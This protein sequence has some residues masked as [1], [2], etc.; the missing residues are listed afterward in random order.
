MQHTKQRG[1]NAVFLQEQEI[2]SNTNVSI[3]ARSALQGS[4]TKNKTKQTKTT[5]IICDSTPKHQFTEDLFV[6]SHYS[7]SPG[8]LS[9]SPSLKGHEPSCSFILL[10]HVWQDSSKDTNFCFLITSSLF[11]DPEGE[12]NL[13]YINVLLH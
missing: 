9:G 13:S 3:H 6:A 7:C 2:H 12:K 5:T 11:S 10:G 1:S 4:Y 8:W